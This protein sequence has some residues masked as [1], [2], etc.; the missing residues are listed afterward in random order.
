MSWCAG[1]VH[2]VWVDM[3]KASVAEQQCQKMTDNKM[4]ATSVACSV[5]CS[6][7]AVENC[8]WTGISGS[9]SIHH[10]TRSQRCQNS[11]RLNTVADLEEIIIRGKVL[12]LHR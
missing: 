6:C 11:V 2:L 3:K 7:R 5:S 1:N 12:E 4:S 8:G 9:A 10:T